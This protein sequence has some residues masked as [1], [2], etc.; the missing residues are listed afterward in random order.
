MTAPLDPGRWRVLRDLVEAA[1]ERPAGERSAWLDAACGDDRALR[2]EVDRLVDAHDR[3]GD[4]LDAVPTA[5][6]D[7]EAVDRPALAHGERVG[8]YVVDQELGRGGMGVVYRAWD[9]RLERW[10]VLKALSP[11]LHAD[12]RARERLELEA[13]AAGRL[14]HEAIATIYALEVLDGE[15]FIVSEYVAGDTLRARLANGPLPV[16]DAVETLLGVARGL[17]AAHELGVVHRDLKPENVMLTPAGRVKVVDF[18][19]ASIDGP[20]PGLTRTGVILGTPGYMAPEQ[21]SGRRADAR[22]DVFALG[23]LLY[24]MIGGHPPFGDSASWTVISAV[25]ERDPPPLGR[26]A[27]GV[28]PALERVVDTCL[29]KAPES[30]YPS[31]G[32]VAAALELVLE[33]LVRPGTGT[34]DRE[35]PPPS[36]PPGVAGQL[37]WLQFH[38]LAASV[39]LALMMIPAWKL[40]SRLPRMTGRAVVLTLLVI[41]A[42]LGTM[43]LHLWFTSRHD[44]VRLADEIARVVPWVRWGNRLFALVL[45]LGGLAV[46]EGS[47]ELAGVC[48]ACAA[49]TLVAG[50]VIEP[51]AIARA[52]NRRS[53]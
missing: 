27:A 13:R 43:R 26:I 33:D 3:L 47:P 24:E 17:G 16:R 12:G 45:G 38:Q 30:R 49:G 28:T 1:V 11:A 39:A 40:M 51:A 23:V 25:L 5:L 34:A 42:A 14:S 48:V 8:A 36:P 2:A 29:A 52:L 32:A 15:L 21:L 22:S 7:D 10:V 46:A 18:G 44:D 37:W 20:G 31:A 53:S 9:T 4:R 50:E 6:L 41:A 35:A 19:I